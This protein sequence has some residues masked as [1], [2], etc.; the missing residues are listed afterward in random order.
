M[1]WFFFLRY[2]L[3]LA[4]PS[5]AIGILTAVSGDGVLPRGQPQLARE[6]RDGGGGETRKPGERGI[7]CG[8][9]TTGVVMGCEKVQACTYLPTS[10]CPCT[11]L[12]NI[13]NNVDVLINN[14][15]TI[16]FGRAKVVS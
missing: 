11:T 6:P 12:M 9:G 3:W 2:V 5:L 8:K 15:L 13:T 4:A 10:L 14:H 16:S 1:Y 7:G